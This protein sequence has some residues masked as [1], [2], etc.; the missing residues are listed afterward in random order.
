MALT[1]RTLSAAIGASDSTFALDSATGVS[2]PN[3]T[4]GSGVTYLLCEQELML[5]TGLS[6]TVVTVLRGYNGTKAV[7]HG[8]SAPVMAGLTT[9][10][11][12]FVAATSG[13]VPFQPF[14]FT[15]M[16]APVTG[17][18][19]IVASGPIFHVTGTVATNIITPPTNFVEG[20]ITIIADGVWTFTSSGVTN[21]IAMNGTV[22]AAKTAVTF[23][24]DAATALWYPSRVA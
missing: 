21:G 24:Y 23:Y 10:F 11:P 8:A 9:D 22:T 2:A 13:V 14:N 20:Q 19:T 1:A 18:A 15:G 3:F 5:V 16:G 7:A 6:S 17:A 12:G 4:T